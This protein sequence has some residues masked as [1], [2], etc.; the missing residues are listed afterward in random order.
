[1]EINRK[2]F[3]SN[4]FIDITRTLYKEGVIMQPHHHNETAISM[5]LSG[6][7]HETVDSKTAIGGI[8]NMVI[9]PRKTIHNNLF[10]NDCAI[11]S[12]YLKEENHNKI[13]HPDMLTEWNWINS[14]NCNH[15][16][17][18]L[19]LNKT[20]KEYYETLNGFLGHFKHQ[21]AHTKQN[22]PPQWIREV[23]TILDTSYNEVIK[24]KDLAKAFNVHPVYLT[25]IFK[26]HFGQS[27]K[28]YLKTLRVNGSM[29]TMF[30]NETPLAQV[31]LENGYCD[32]SH[33]NR[34]FKSETNLT[35]RHFKK[36]IQ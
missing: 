27:I 21:K 9:K 3:F 16:L 28:S 8:A 25:K 10:S 1:M 13:H 7:I 5:I 35:P 17:Q 14:G 32:Q 18:S 29:A 36:L 31:A 2:Y 11:I 19:I 20:E 4:P 22:K 34:N 15:F 6:S 12:I 23:K 30:Q 26:K 33:L 24:S